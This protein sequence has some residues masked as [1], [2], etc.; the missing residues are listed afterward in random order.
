MARKIPVKR[1]CIT[2]LLPFYVSRPREKT[3]P[4][5][6][7]ELAQGVTVTSRMLEYQE[8]NKDLFFDGEY[9]YEF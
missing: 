7:D 6:E 2:C 1:T 5:C 9:E 4:L 3:C 8:K